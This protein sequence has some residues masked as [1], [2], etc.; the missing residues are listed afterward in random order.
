[1]APPDLQKQRNILLTTFRRD[2]SP[3]GTPVDVAVKDDHHAYFRT[4]SST[5]KVARI[6]RNPKVTVAP[7]TGRGTQTGPTVSAT[8]RLLDGDEARA[9]AEAIDRK[10]PI[11][12]GVFVRLYHRVRRLET[13]HYE[14]S[15]DDA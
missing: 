14:L 1:M 11:L 12:E 4:W 15:F 10:Y 13:V 9:A 3:V 7:C 5:G 6:A 2:G 8:A